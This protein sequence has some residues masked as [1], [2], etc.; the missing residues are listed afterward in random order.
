MRISDK[1]IN[2]ILSVLDFLCL[3]LIC[4]FMYKF[5]SPYTHIPI[6]FKGE[7]FY[8]PYW[9]V[10]VF[11]LDKNPFHVF[12]SSDHSWYLYSL[13]RVLTQK[14]LADFL[15][16]HP[17]LYLE[18]Y[19]VFFL[20]GYYML[21][22]FSLLGN[23]TKYFVKTRFSCLLIPF[24]ALL[25]LHPVIRSNCIWLLYH[26]SWG[27][28]Y[29]F[30]PIFL[31]LLLSLIERLYVN[32]QKPT[33]T[34]FVLIMCFILILSISHELHR[35]ILCFGSLI[36]LIVHK[37]VFKNGFKRK[38][39]LYWLLLVLVC[40]LNFFNKTFIS[41]FF[42]RCIFTK[43]SIDGGIFSFQ[44]LIQ[45]FSGYFNYLI[46]HNILLINILSIL[47]ILIHYFVGDK[48]R[49]K[50]FYLYILSLLSSVFTFF[51]V[52]MI[53]NE[54]S[55]FSFE[56]QGLRLMLIVIFIYCILSAFG[57][58]LKMSDN[59]KLKI[60]LS[61]FA[62]LQ[63]FTALSIPDFEKE[64][65]YDKN[66]SKEIKRI[67]YMIEKMF[68]F[69][70]KK[71]K[72]YYYIKRTF[73]INHSSILYLLYRYDKNAS[74]NDYKIIEVCEAD[75]DINKS[76][77]CR[78]KFLKLFEEKTGQTIT[79]EELENPDFSVFDKYTE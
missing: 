42:E 6:M 59:K 43:N 62:F 53:G 66:Q 58:L 44:Y 69:H 12:S 74:K 32:F 71:Q 2:I 15:G 55:D 50:R 23:F 13:I 31:L 36:L 22:L 27:L 37:L 39:L 41:W 54:Y 68:I 35:F 77:D 64:T 8:E 48:E 30:L 25:F 24:I 19:H 34:E 29:I 70:G 9:N 46:K 61:V 67:A 63:F 18:K 38:Y 49:N 1:Q 3:L 21:L 52:I 10:A 60:I 20:F 7:D 14:H 65:L 5:V 16:L 72:K 57:Y 4:I 26:S 40:S 75:L 51:I 56:H 45:Y 47:L 33:K 17:V 78:N 73:A 76:A 28:A 11:D 79:K